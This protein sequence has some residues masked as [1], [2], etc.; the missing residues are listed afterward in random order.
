MNV[1]LL[2]DVHTI[3]ITH[4]EAI[5]VHVDLDIELVESIAMVSEMYLVCWCAYTIIMYLSISL[6]FHVIFIKRND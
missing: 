6:L 5:I 3:V 4:T 1:Q 2:E